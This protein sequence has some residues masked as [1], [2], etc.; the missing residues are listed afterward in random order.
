MKLKNAFLA[1]LISLV[2]SSALSIGLCASW[3]FND[4]SVQISHL[5]GSVLKKYFEEQLE[6]IRE[7]RASER[8]FYQ[9][10]TDIYASESRMVN[11]L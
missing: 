11:D 3:F 9:K 5:D 10:I 2:F 8:K 7:I 1:T 6:R 4:N